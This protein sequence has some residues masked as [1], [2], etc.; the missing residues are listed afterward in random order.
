M[1]IKSAFNFGE[2]SRIIA[3]HEEDFSDFG[4]VV[5]QGDREGSTYTYKDNQSSV[6]A[7]AHLDTVQQGTWSTLIRVSKEQVIVSPRLDD[8]LG[9]YIITRMLPK[10]GI[11]C[12]WLLTTGEEIGCSSAEL[13]QTDKA[14]NWAFSFDRAGIDVVLYQY[15]SKALK[16][17][18]RKSGFSV[19]LGSFSDLASLDV[20]CSG[21]NFGCGYREPH[22]IHS[23]APLND[24][25]S[26]VSLFKRFF[27]RYATVR[28]PYDKESSRWTYRGYYGQGY[29]RISYPEYTQDGYKPYSDRNYAKQY[30]DWYETGYCSQCGM[31]V[32][33]TELGW[34]KTVNAHVCLDCD[35]ELS[36]EGIRNG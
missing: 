27:Q 17:I 22:S 10:L 7:V 13:F 1:K 9:V 11:T 35:Y 25:L 12:D 15:E 24:V 30:L 36:Q 23:Y 16:R 5:K 2:L 8:R 33:D 26:M 6:L 3:R 20:G 34:S 18:L 31:N 28:L 4:C 21:I 29:G 32:P 19:G 14:Y